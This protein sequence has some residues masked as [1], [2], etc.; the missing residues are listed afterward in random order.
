MYNTINGFGYVIA[1]YT[2]ETE[3]QMTRLTREEKLA[4]ETMALQGAW[5]DFRASY[6]ERFANLLYEFGKLGNAFQVERLNHLTYLFKSDESYTVEAELFVTLTE[7][8]QNDYIWEF[9]QVERQVTEHYAKKAEAFRLY[10]VKRDALA[11]VRSTLNDEELK[12]L[13]L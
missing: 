11:K 5:N 7:E 6:P 4:M 10:N 3:L 2:K 12:L 8:P 13:G 1:S 9:E